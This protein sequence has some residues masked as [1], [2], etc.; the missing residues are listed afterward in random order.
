MTGDG[1]SIFRSVRRFLRTPK[2]LLL[3]GFVP[4]LA[5]AIAQEDASATVPALLVVVITASLFD[6]AAFQLLYNKWI[7]PSGAILTG[8]ILAIVLAPTEPAYAEIAGAV[9]AILS[10][11]ALR[12]RLSNIFNRPR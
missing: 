11:H 4:I 7:F 10:K 5:L 2:G 9:I 12:T 8:L 1:G 3:V 6:I